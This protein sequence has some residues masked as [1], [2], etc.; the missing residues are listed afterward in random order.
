MSLRAN[1]DLGEVEFFERLVR[2]SVNQRQR[3]EYHYRTMEIMLAEYQVCKVELYTKYCLGRALVTVEIAGQWGL[4]VAEVV[5][6]VG[7]HSVIALASINNVDDA[8]NAI[9]NLYNWVQEREGIKPQQERA[10]ELILA[11]SPRPK[12]PRSTSRAEKV[13][14]LEAKLANERARA[15][16]AENL[17]QRKEREKE[18]VQQEVALLRTAVIE[19][20]ATLQ[21]DPHAEIAAVR[22]QIEATTAK[23]KVLKA[24]LQELLSQVSDAA[25]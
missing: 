1:R 11:A 6:T 22:R 8:P 20:E 9:R 24:R 15:R 18:E 17:L 3:I 5:L 13:S 4:T 25:E 23:L 14:H 7:A 10:A 19:V 21:N 16:A 2:L 12:T